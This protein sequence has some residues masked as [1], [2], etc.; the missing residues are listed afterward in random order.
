MTKMPARFSSPS[1]VAAELG[2]ASLE[3]YFGQVLDGLV[4]YGY[5]PSR[6]FAWLAA[7]FIAGTVY[8]TVNQ[9]APLD[10][11]HHPSFQPVL[12]TANLVIPVI[13]LGQTGTWI[14]TVTGQWVAATLTALGWI[15]ATAAVAG[16]TRVLTR[17]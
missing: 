4:G 6:A 13:K 8:F 11:A 15:F 5:R 17:I 9:P 12:Y 16:I 7:V 1:N 3:G 2:S 10:A 14:L